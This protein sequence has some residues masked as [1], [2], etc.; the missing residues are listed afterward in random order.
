MLHALTIRKRTEKLLVGR[1]INMKPTAYLSFEH[2]L[3]DG[4]YRLKEPSGTNDTWSHSSN[5]IK[6]SEDQ[7]WNVV[8]VGEDWYMPDYFKDKQLELL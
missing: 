5:A 8:W 3:E 4:W 6:F 2:G 7:G 1:L